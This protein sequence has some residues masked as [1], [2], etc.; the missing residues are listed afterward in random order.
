MKK[1]DLMNRYYILEESLEDIGKYFKCSRETIRRN[2]Q[3]LSLKDRDREFTNEDK[4]QAINIIKN[5]CRGLSF[6]RDMKFISM[7]LMH[8]LSVVVENLANIWL[9]LYAPNFDVK[10]SPECIIHNIKRGEY[11][12]RQDVHNG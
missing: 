2:I 11:N 3:R 10:I 12:G 6:H 1:I 8:R 4:L 9:A 5:Q 7:I